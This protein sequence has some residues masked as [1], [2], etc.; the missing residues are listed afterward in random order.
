MGLTTQDKAINEIAREIESLATQ[1]RKAVNGKGN[2][3]KGN[4]K[5]N[6]Q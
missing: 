5:R 4:T 1:I 2:Q 6:S 3:I